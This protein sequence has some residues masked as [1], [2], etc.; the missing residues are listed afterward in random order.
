ME[1]ELN[2]LN[3]FSE[4]GFLKII[5]DFDN[6]L[7][8]QELFINFILLNLKKK[9]N[10]KILCNFIKL[11]VLKYENL[12]NKILISELLNFDIKKSFIINLFNNNNKNNIKLLNDN[13]YNIIEEDF[14]NI[15][16][17]NNII[18]KIFDNNIITKEN[19]DLE[20]YDFLFKNIM[21]KYEDLFLEW[22]F[23]LLNLYNYRCK[24]YVQKEYNDN[25][26]YIIINSLFK[27]ISLDNNCNYNI[28]NNEILEIINNNLDI[29]NISYNEIKNNNKNYINFILIYKFINITIYY[30]LEDIEYYILKSKT[31]SDKIEKINNSNNNI[32]NNFKIISDF[33]IQQNKKNINK[34][35][36]IINILTIKLN[37]NILE[38]IYI[39][40]KKILHCIIDNDDKLLEN[41]EAFSNILFNVIDLYIYKYKHI[42]QTVNE[43]YKFFEYLC[44]IFYSKK[45]NINI[46]IKFLTLLNYI[47][48]NENNYKN[49]NNDKLLKLLEKTILFYL[50][51]DSYEDEYYKLEMKNR[52]INMYN[53]Y[54]L[55]INKNIITNI[56]INIL[57]KFI[58]ILNED[59]NKC[60]NYLLIYIVQDN[61]KLLNINKILLNI[62][63]LNN[64]I[65]NKMI[66]KIDDNILYNIISKY[67][68]N[69]K[70]IST[71]KYDKNLYLKELNNILYE[72]TVFY[73]K[74]NIDN[75]FL[76][77][78]KEDTFFD[79][80]VFKN[81]S[82]ELN[83]YY[84]IKNFIDFLYKIEH[85]EY[86]DEI[87]KINYN[88][89]PD[90]FLDPIYNTLIEE[91]IIL[92][93]SNKIMDYNIIKQHLLYGE[94]DPFNRDLLTIEMIDK[95]NNLEENI[96]INKNLKKK[97][98]DWKNEQ[99]INNL[100]SK[101]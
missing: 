2:I 86:D 31:I 93:S 17:D 61:S 97:I 84:K 48:I 87:I 36:E 30:T 98:L 80:E 20:F 9:Y 7:N 6:L 12:I 8:N 43:K 5:E 89:I 74:I 10:I 59:I 67:N 25:I 79:L 65:I 26:L 14:K 77:Y 85:L 1:N 35:D 68:N 37:N 94:F 96:I 15:T 83:K 72:M 95:Y 91:P 3:I 19:S 45:S 44:N 56:N 21:E 52:I 18:Y 57:S 92:P 55:Y 13:I 32:L 71:F 54:L 75:K 50:S 51:L 63:K 78:I 100:D 99:D 40:Y 33:I 76:K 53:I 42:F 29:V 88:N 90:E 38:Y 41:N 60:I 81:K 66:N 49:I 27:Y 82:T 62:F 69:F 24:S 58:I 34:Y 64:F 70:L 22:I 28:N 11:D 73:D 39:F 4:K 47:I 16:I 23:K 46:N 101:L